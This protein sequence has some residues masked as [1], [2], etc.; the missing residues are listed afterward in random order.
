MVE[1]PTE[2]Q[3]EQLRYLCSDVLFDFEMT[4]YLIDDLTERNKLRERSQQYVNR[5]QEII[6]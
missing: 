2:A 1:L 5:F 6:H 4:Q 3:I